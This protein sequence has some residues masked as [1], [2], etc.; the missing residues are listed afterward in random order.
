MTKPLNVLKSVGPKL[1]P[2]FKTVAIYFVLYGSSE[3]TSLLFCIAKCLP[4]VSLIFFVLLHGMSLNEYYRYSRLILIGL[5]FSAVGDAFLVWKA[6]YLNFECGVLMFAMAQVNYARAFGFRPFNVYAG[7]AFTALG[8]GFYSFLSPGLKGMME[9]LCPMYLILICI[10]GWRAVA[11]VQFFDELWTWTKL[12]GCA[13]AI[14]FMTSDLLIAIDT[15]IVKVPFSHQ[16]IMVTYYAAQLGISLSVVDSQVEE[17]I[18]IQTQ[19]QS[20]DVIDNVKGHLEHLSSQLNKENVRSQLESLSNRV[21]TVKENL[22]H[23]V[24]TV[25]ENLSHRVDTVKEKVDSVKENLSNRVDTV[26]ENLSQRVDTV[27]E[28]VDSVKENLSQRVDYVKENLSH[29]V[30]CVREN[31]TTQVGHLSHRVDCVKENLSQRVDS[32]KEKVD[33]VKEN[34]SQRVDSVK[35]NLSQGVDNVRGQLENIS[36]QITNHFAAG[37]PKQD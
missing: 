5:I 10:M 37:P 18:R 31:L 12:C 1:V 36:G 23:R 32:V 2:F 11:R 25:K 27:K 6:S 29:G 8:C 14:F 9:Y 15:F 30:G 26:K 33:S 13:G 21:D 19:G 34:L 35:E 16:L 17:V 20:P 24:D 28:K 4:I 22:S 7:A 3:S